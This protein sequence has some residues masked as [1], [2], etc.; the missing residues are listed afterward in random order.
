[1]RNIELKS[2]CGIYSLQTKT[3]RGNYIFLEMLIMTKSVKFN[4]ASVESF[5]RRVHVFVHGYGYLFRQN[6]KNIQHALNILLLLKP[7]F[8]YVNFFVVRTTI[9]KRVYNVYIEYKCCVGE[10]YHSPFFFFIKFVN[11]RAF[12]FDWYMY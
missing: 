5:K 12:R 9:E 3:I 4:S 11:F 10:V 1:M 7:F 2:I 6:V 8:C